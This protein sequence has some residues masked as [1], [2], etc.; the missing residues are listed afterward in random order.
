MAGIIVI[1]LLCVFARVVFV[2]WKEAFL[3]EGN[4][5]ASVKK[6]KRV[7]L[8]LIGIIT[9]II[10][11][12]ALINSI[13]FTTEQQIGFTTFLGKNTIIEN[14]GMHFKI[15][16]LAKSYIMDGTTQGM[17]IGYQMDNDESV[18]EDS[19]MITSDFNFIN[20]DFYVEYRISPPIKYHYSTSDPEA[21]L[22]NIALAAIRNT[23]GQVDVDSAMTTGK[24]EIES[25]V[26]DD[27]ILELDK[28]QTGLTVSNISIQ[29]TE[30]PT[31]EVQA[32]FKAVED[33]KQGAS[34]AVN[35][36]NK[37]TNERIPEA[38]AAASKIKS[39]AEATH[40]ERVNQASE[41]VAK[42]NAIYDEYQKNPE[43][44]KQRLYLD[45]LGEVLPNMEIVIGDGKVIYVTGNGE[46]SL[47][48]VEMEGNNE[49]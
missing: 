2:F 14:A 6:V 45:T 34:T 33:A 15:P 1:F 48:D 32:A 19:L 17:P 30:A 4:S 26:L 29:D 49:K 20:M 31:E 22:E 28:H 36:A 9:V 24:S 8:F 11:V 18:Y 39:S 43:V 47:A 25:K 16:F 12:V 7:R 42:F 13:F 46:K 5:K 37:Y 10:L 38:E 21:F 35:E 23:V 3:I 40:T 41:E 44:I 27:I